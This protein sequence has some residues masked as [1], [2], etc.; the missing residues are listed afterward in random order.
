MYIHTARPSETGITEDGTIRCIYD[1]NGNLT[2]KIE[3]S[4]AWTYEWTAENELNKTHADDIET[5]MILYM[6]PVSAFR[7]IDALAAAALPA[8]SAGAAPD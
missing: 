3:G 6:Q 7:D 2:Q 1:S 8:G 4:D 5:S